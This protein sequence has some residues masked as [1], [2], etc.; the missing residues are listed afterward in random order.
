MDK[1]IV[2]IFCNSGSRPSGPRFD[3][4]EIYYRTGPSRPGPELQNILTMVLVHL[5]TTVVSSPARGQDK[6]LFIDELFDLFGSDKR[7]QFVGTWRHIRRS[8]APGR[9]GSTAW[10]GGTHVSKIWQG[11]YPVTQQPRDLL[12][13]AAVGK[14]RAITP[15]F[16]SVPPTARCGGAGGEE[17]QS[18]AEERT[19]LHSLETVPGKF[20]EA[21]FSP[22][23]KRR[24]S[25]R[26][27]ASVYWSHDPR[28]R[29]P[30]Q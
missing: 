14:R 26:P 4:S 30:L 1:T 17:L 10:R 2:R 19:L 22:A 9:C 6:Y 8:G 28:K 18:A 24:H 15:R 3:H 16:A 23:R 25:D 12:A 13:T 27:A 21:L 11:V 20:A 29:A 5:S 7:G